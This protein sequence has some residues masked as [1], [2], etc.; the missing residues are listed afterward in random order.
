M[1]PLKRVQVGRDGAV[2]NTKAAGNLTVYPF[3]TD[4]P[5]TS[6]LNFAKGQTIADMVIATVSVDG[7]ILV[8]NTSNG[9]LD[10]IVDIAGYYIG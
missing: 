1:D 7:K 2:T 9:P 6:N 3:G 10:L 4:R 8:T 5:S